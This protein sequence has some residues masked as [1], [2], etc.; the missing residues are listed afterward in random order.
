MLFHKKMVGICFIVASGITTPYV[1]SQETKVETET[2]TEEQLEEVIEDSGE[3]SDGMAQG[4]VVGEASYN[5]EDCQSLID[6]ED[7]KSG[8]A[9]SEE[10]EGDDDEIASDTE[11]LDLDKCRE[12]IK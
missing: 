11:Q 10:S 1:F 4:D 8:E 6:A 7:K 3:K 12:L 9:K 2:V 5:I